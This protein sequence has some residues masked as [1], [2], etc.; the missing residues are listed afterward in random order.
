MSISDRT[1]DVSL[2]RRLRLRAPASSADLLAANGLE[3]SRILDRGIELDLAQ[4]LDVG[5]H[6]IQHCLSKPIAAF[7]ARRPQL[8][9]TCAC[10]QGSLAQSCSPPAS[11][12][13]FDGE[14]GVIPIEKR[15]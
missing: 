10:Q 14:N 4:C 7:A 9:T 6:K 13:R 11:A 3:L 8:S 1:E 5:K 2:Q 12:D 15:F